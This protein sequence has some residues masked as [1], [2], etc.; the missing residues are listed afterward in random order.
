M[1][2]QLIQ[3]KIYELRGMRVMLDFDLA[4]L[5]DVENRTL[6]QTVKRNIERFPSDFM[7]QLTKQ[8][9][10]EVITICDNL[11][12]NAK[13][14]PATPFAFTQEG[15]AMLSGVLRSSLAIQVNISIMRAFVVIRQAVLSTTSTTKDIEILK[16]QIR[17]LYEDIGSLNKDHEVY[18][19]QFDDIYLALTE[20]ASKEKAIGTEFKEIGYDAEWRKK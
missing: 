1:E 5:Y 16:L 12:E 18:E 8:E 9:W 11:P 6:K 7:F 17:E 20:L 13:F 10:T 19:Q 3:N 2:I 14:S 15:I 4:Q